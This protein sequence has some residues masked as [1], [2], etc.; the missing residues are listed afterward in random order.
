VI[1]VQA[2]LGEQ[3]FHVARPALVRS[4]IKVMPETVVKGELCPLRNPADD[5]D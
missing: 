3:L 4:E 5:P 2:S 1:G